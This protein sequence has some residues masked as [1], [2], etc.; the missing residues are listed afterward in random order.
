M[1]VLPKARRRGIGE[2]LIKSLVREGIKKKLSFIT[3]EVR[4]SNENA[5]KLYAKQGFKEVGRRK[6]FYRLPDEDGILYTLEF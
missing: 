2:E 4:E 3:L 1:A 5:R 6:R